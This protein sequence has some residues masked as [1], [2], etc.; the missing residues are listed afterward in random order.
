MRTWRVGFEGFDPGEERLQ[1][2]LCTLGNGYFANR[3]AA[4]EAAVGTTHY[5]GSYITGWYDRLSSRITGR[6]VVNEDLVNAPNWLPVTFR[7]EGGSWFT[8]DRFPLLDY[9]QELDLRQRLLSRRPRYRDRAGRLTA[10]EQQRLVSMDDPHVAAL[11]TTIR[12]ENWS[13]PLEIRS[14]LDGLVCTGG[15]ARY[16]GLSRVYLIFR[17]RGADG[18]VIWLDVKTAT[19]RVRI[20]LAAR[21]TIRP[22]GALGRETRGAPGWIAQQLTVEAYRDDPVTVRPSRCTPPVTGP[23][24]STPKRPGWRP[25]R[26]GPWPSCASGTSARGSSC[27]WR[28]GRLDVGG[29]P[30]QRTVN[31]HMFHILQTLSPHTVGLDVGVPARGLHG[32]AHRG[33]VLVAQSM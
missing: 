30:A 7:I 29:G 32:A 27:V 4:P 21:T 16:R 28:R 2:A 26:R 5:P 33:H 11:R 17:S 8:P 15:V 31:L 20:A 18:D 23:S 25:G 19:T 12:A 6:T 3:G 22:E 10:V 14:G 9:T 24:R 13:G 1:E